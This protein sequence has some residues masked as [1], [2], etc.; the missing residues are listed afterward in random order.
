VASNEFVLRGLPSAASEVNATYLCRLKVTWLAS[1]L[2]VAAVS[3]K[4]EEL[5]FSGFYVVRVSYYN[6]SNGFSYFV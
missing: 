1:A 6:G 5:W 2:K 4:P 3:S